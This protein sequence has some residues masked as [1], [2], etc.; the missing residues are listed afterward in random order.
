MGGVHAARARVDVGEYR[1]S[2]DLLDGGNSR[3]SRV[4]HGDHFLSCLHP[5]G[6]QR[7]RKGIGPVSD[8]NAVPH[9]NIGRPLTLKSLDLVAEDVPPACQD[10]IEGR[11]YGLLTDSHLRAWICERNRFTLHRSPASNAWSSARKRRV[12]APPPH[13]TTSSVAS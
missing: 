6:Q 3:D 10:P 7:Q 5:D 4:R 11:P 13:K 8:S 9:A 1:D 12:S 2:T